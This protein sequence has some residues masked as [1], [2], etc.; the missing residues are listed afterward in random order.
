MARIIFNQ[1]PYWFIRVDKI[2]YAKICQDDPKTV[3]ICCEGATDIIPMTWE[4]KESA[5]NFY[6]AIK[7]AVERV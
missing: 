5:L 3:Y 1:D 4:T 7:G 2:T 6:N